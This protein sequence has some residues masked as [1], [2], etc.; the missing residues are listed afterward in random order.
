M[1]SHDRVV[2]PAEQRQAAAD[3]TGPT[4]QQEKEKNQMLA[5]LHSV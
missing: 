2:T 4:P 1:L 3:T 5:P